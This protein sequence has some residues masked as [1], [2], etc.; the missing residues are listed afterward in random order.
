[1][2]ESD[3]VQLILMME[4]RPHGGT[5]DWR[6]LGTTVPETPQKAIHPNP[7]RCVHF[8]SNMG[9]NKVKTNPLQQVEK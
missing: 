7:R 5:D 3:L 6:R 2:Q 9:F 1:M 8:K 4:S